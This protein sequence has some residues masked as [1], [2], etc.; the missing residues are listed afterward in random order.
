MYYLDISEMSSTTADLPTFTDDYK[1]VCLTV[2]VFAL[3]AF[4]AAELIVLRKISYKVDTSALLTLVLFTVIPFLRTFQ[5]IVR[6]FIYHG[7]QSDNDLKSF[8][9]NLLRFI[10]SFFDSV[11]EKLRWLTLYYFI[12]EMEQVK[13]K[14]HA[15]NH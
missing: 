7:E 9:I 14:V 13:I 11:A 1:Y 2:N 4:L 8:E 15:N 12:L 10:M 5:W 3:V 6:I